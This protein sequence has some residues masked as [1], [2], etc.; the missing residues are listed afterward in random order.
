[1][2]TPTTD[3]KDAEQTNYQKYRGKCR[4]MCEEAIKADPTLTIVR[5]HYYCPIW[6]TEEQHWWT[7]RPDGSIFDPT[8]RQ[9]PSAGLGI[10]TPFDGMVECAQC[11]KRVPEKEASFESRYAF[12]SY[13]C[14]GRF[15][16]VL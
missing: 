6:N 3:K 10:Y 12:C 11:G 4:E 15:V 7:V 13:Q 14:H 16:G 9:F 8:A 1:M 5:G 2:N